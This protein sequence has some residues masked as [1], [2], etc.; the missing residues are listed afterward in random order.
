M[1]DVKEEVFFFF[2]SGELICYWCPCPM[3][4]RGLGGI[5]SKETVSTLFI[6]RVNIN[7]KESFMSKPACFYVFLRS[8][9]KF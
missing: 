5:E 2:P 8:K 1:C 4:F 3:P 7:M 6:Q 9:V